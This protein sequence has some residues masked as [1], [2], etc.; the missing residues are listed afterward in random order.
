MNEM[1][2]NVFN[3]P[4]RARVEF[5][6]YS[7][8]FHGVTS[9]AEPVIMHE[10]DVVVEHDP[11]FVLSDEDCQLFVN[12]LWNQGFRPTKF[13]NPD[14]AIAMQTRHLEDMRKIAFMYLEIGRKND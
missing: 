11:T 10:A 14:A 5:Y 12:E 7:R 3:N 13:E 9:I 8:A 6:L 1:R 2:L 4:M